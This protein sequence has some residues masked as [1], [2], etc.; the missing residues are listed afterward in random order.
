[1]KLKLIAIISLIIPLVDLQSAVKVLA[2]S[3]SSRAGSYNQELVE[4][5][6]RIARKNGAEVTVINLKDYEMP[7]YQEDLEASQGMP[8]N[9][10]RFRKLM[11][12]HDR[13]MIA[14][15]E[16]NGSLTALLKNALDWASRSE[17]AQFSLEAFKGKKFAV[18]SASPGQGGGKRS[19]DHLAQILTSLGGEVVKT[20]VVVPQAHQA[21]INGQGLK[22]D[23]LEDQLKQEVAEL[24]R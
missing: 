24:L 5:A 17:N 3:G 9:A 6:S 11:L 12:E 1:M 21:L 19:L 13:I 8:E 4:E 7:I 20:K 23:S 10:R 2:F 14:T 16:Y 18:M 22:N 15:P